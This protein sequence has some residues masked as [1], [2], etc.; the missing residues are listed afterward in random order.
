[1]ELS[2]KAFE[3][4]ATFTRASVATRVNSSGYIETVGNDIP[5]F[6][7]DPVTH[8]L[9]GL[10]IEEA[11]TNLLLRSDDFSN[12]VWSKT[13]VTIGADAAGS[14]D[15]VTGFDKIIPDNSA[16]LS[17]C[18]VRQT[19][20][21]PAVSKTYTFSVFVSG[22]GL[23]R[24]KV[25]ANDT[26]ATVNSA[27]TM[28][29]LVD[30]SIVTPAA[31]SGTFSQA[32]VQVYPFIN[33]IFR[34]ALTFKTSTETS[35]QCRINVADFSATVGNGSSGILVW[36]ADLELGETV[37]SYKPTTS[38][39]FARAADTA[40]ING[41]TLPQIFKQGEGSLMAVVRPMAF[42]GTKN[43]RILEI[44]DEVQWYNRV[45]IAA[46]PYGT[47][48][49]VVTKAT[50]TESSL[51]VFSKWVPSTR[52]K[53]AVAFQTNDF[54][55]SV[56]GGIVTDTGSTAIP[57]GISGMC[58]GYVPYGPEEALNGWV[59]S[60]RYFPKRLSNTQLQAL[61]A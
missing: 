55:L 11:R 59:E 1:M 31:S 43:A 4:I 49:G 46:D 8:Q 26:G 52:V 32:S 40:L 3:E 45:L 50:V 14:L 27:S 56:D 34:V 47:V 29:S 23:S 35:I 61:T 39:T 53:V 37:T 36:G 54:A 22:A 20:S 58:I 57:S 9:L 18:I 13:S 48:I 7:Y 5:R 38:A 12:A 25:S 2:P 24:V 21:K 41:S 6:D 33:G 19:V 15:G 16:A 42:S 44:N 10:L 51:G 30:G 28:I 60:I 17:S